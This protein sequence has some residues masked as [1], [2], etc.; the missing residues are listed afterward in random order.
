MAV[1]SDREGPR[2]SGI[3]ACMLDIARVKAITLDLDD[4]LWPSWPTIERAEHVLHA[5]LTEHAP[6]AAVLFSS[7]AAL[8]EIRN[9]VA[10]QRP[11]IR[12]DLSAVRRES[13]RVALH[14]AGEDPLLAE[15]AFEAFFAARQQV[16]LFG[17][18]K[19]ALE[20]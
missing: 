4:T 17:D 18:A 8:R 1:P 2:S 9:H 3:L 12:P 7:P 10:A 6:M 5:W 19:A 15:P 16:E 13:I 11:E 14:R 20:F